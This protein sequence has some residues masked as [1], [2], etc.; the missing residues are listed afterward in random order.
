MSDYVL[1]YTDGPAIPS[2]LRE[3]ARGHEA[4]IRWRNGR[5]FSRPER[6]ADVV[7]TG[8]P[9]IREAYEANDVEVRDMPTLGRKNEAT[10]RRYVPEKGDAGWVKVKDRKTGEYVEGA[11]KRSEEEAQKVADQLNNG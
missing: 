3:W 10:Q 7:Y 6:R 8:D 9:D 5:L 2:H 11:S 1:C 4:S